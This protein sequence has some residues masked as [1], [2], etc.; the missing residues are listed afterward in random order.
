MTTVVA[1]VASPVSVSAIEID[2]VA[3]RLPFVTPLSSVT[4]ATV[5]V[6]ITAASLTPL[7]V[8]LTGW[9]EIPPFLSLTVTS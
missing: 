3:T 1:N 5:G 4:D 9:V 2:P 6:P 8:K 7:I